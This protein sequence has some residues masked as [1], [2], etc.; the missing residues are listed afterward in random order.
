[1]ENFG[2]SFFHFGFEQEEDLLRKEEYLF[3]DQGYKVLGYEEH[4]VLDL[5][6]N[7]IGH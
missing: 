2:I 3:W 5:R 1:L 7:L 6:W 4:I